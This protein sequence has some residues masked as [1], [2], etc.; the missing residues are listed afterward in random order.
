MCYSRKCRKLSS[1]PG[2]RLACPSLAVFGP[3][4]YKRQAWTRWS[5]K[6]LAVLTSMT[7]LPCS[8]NLWCRASFLQSTH[9]FLLLP[10]GSP[11]THLIPRTTAGP[12][13]HFPNR[14]H[15]F[16]KQSCSNRSSLTDLADYAPWTQGP[17]LPHV[18]DQL[19]G[20]KISN[21]PNG[22]S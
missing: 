13:Q 15:W 7:D 10:S 2:S 19:R 20:N 18:S 16:S 11:I 9:G 1:A 4:L 12:G 8:I 14:D 17:Q 3:L 5:L 6:P 21:F 22:V